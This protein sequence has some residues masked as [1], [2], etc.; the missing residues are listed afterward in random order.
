MDNG[1]CSY[2]RYLDG[3]EEAFDDIVKDLFDPLVFFIDRYVHDLSA[4]E[5]IA[6]DAFTDLVVHKHRYD[7]RVTLKTYLFMIGR[8]R[9][10]NYIKRRNRRQSVPLTAVQETVRDVAAEEAF[11]AEERA[12]LVHEALQGLPVDMQAAVHLVYFDGLSYEEAARVM[13]KTKKQID[14]LLYRAK[15][16]LRRT[17]GKEGA[18]Y[19][20]L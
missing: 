11:Y 12:M 10:L 17:I 3:E 9:A 7:F 15:Q 2:R 5:D 18:V 1:A 20:K 8:S 16:E 19:E 4:S 13:K 6:I 14:N